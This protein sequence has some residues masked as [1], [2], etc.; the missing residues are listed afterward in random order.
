MGGGGGDAVAEAVV[1]EFE[2]EEAAGDSVVGRSGTT[3]NNVQRMR[4]GRTSTTLGDESE[5]GVCLY[6][7]VEAGAGGGIWTPRP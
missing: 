6:S 3:R 2:E 7:L 1:V 4:M 5:I